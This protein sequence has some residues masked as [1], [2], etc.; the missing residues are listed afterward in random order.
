MMVGHACAPED[1]SIG[2]PFTGANG[3]L[4]RDLLAHAGIASL[5]ECY[6][7]NCCKCA[8]YT[9]RD[10]KKE[11]KKKHWKA[12]QPHFIKE[13]EHVQPKVLVALGAQAFAWLT[14][15]S[16]VAKFYR[17]SLPC[18][19]NEDIP[20]FP[21]RQPAQLF[22]C[23]D[24]VEAQ[25]LR[26]AMIQDLQ[27]LKN[28]VTSIV[29]KS[30]AQ[31]SDLDYKTITN[32][33]E[34][35][36]LFAELERHPVLGFDLET[37]DLFPG[38]DER[39]L[40]AGFSW[41]PKVG[42][43]LPLHAR[44][45][46]ATHYWPDGYVEQE[47]VPRLRKILSEKE[48][49]GHNAIQFDQ[50]WTRAK[51]GVHKLRILFD[52][53]LAHFAI[54]EER[55]TH[56]LEQIAV[57]YGGMKTWKRDFNPHDTEQLCAY[58]CKDVD[59]VSRLRP[60]FESM[61]SQGERWLLDNVLVPLAH[62]LFEVEYA[63]VR[64]SETALTDLENQLTA[65]IDASEDKI[66]QHKAVL[67]FM[68]D[69]N[70]P[71]DSESP[72][73]VRDVMQKYL[74]LKKVK[75]T[76]SGLYSTDKEALS[77]HKNDPFVAD[78]QENRRLRKLRSTYCSQLREELRNGVVHTSY[79]VH[80]TVTGRPSSSDP[81]LMNIPRE[82][83]AA[84]VLDDGS[85]IKKL[86]LPDPG[87][88]LLQADFCLT[89]DTEVIT[90]HGV[91]ELRDVVAKKPAVLSSADGRSVQFSKVTAGWSNGKKPVF[92]VIT[93]DGSFVRCT[94]EHRWMLKNGTFKETRNLQPGDRLAHVKSGTRGPKGAYKTWYVGSYFNYF[95]QHQV[96]AE[97][98]FGPPPEGF[99]VDHIDGNTERNV[100]GNIRYLPISQ[101]RSQG[102]GR[103]W[104]SASSAEREAKLQSL[105]EGN[106][107]R[108]YS[109]ALNPNFG[110][111]RG[112]ERSCPVCGAGF[113]SYPS[114][115]KIFCSKK[116]AANRHKAVVNHK[117]LVV[118]PCAEEEEVFD[119]TVDGTHTFVL[120]NGM[121]SHNCQAELRVLA[122][123]SGDQQLLGI[124]QRGEDAHAATAAIVY[125]IPLS[126][127]TKAQRN[128]AKP[129]NFGIPYGMSEEGLIQ[130]FMEAGGS[131]Q[132]AKNFLT[133]HQKKFHDVW[134]YME[135]QA[136]IVRKFRKQTTYFGRSRRY[137]QVD[138]RALRQAYN[139]P[140]QSLA[141]E[142]T[143]LCLI[144]IAKTIR[145]LQLNAR[146][147][148]TVYD[149]IAWSVSPEHFWTLAKVAHHIMS[150]IHFPWMKVP[151][152]ADLEAGW[153]WGDLKKV[154][155]N[156]G[157][158]G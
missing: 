101:N 81:N 18:V 83:T 54:D 15:F 144:R 130:K 70:K 49:F 120:A 98:L 152:A 141:S 92:L 6:F 100:T 154:D 143:L 55:G 153:N 11:L 45:T 122:S 64:L 14:G 134:K 121:I 7:T 12:C 157:K 26:S 61:L 51:L 52:T 148:L 112:E 10:Q 132:E 58:L 24:P 44:G 117:V 149:S 77:F 111:R 48:V 105:Q 156:L 158:V 37:S 94:A 108:G 95:P 35:L 25:S 29:A 72:H 63:G 21:L 107:R 57:V 16:G 13:L 30:T 102:A 65:K 28:H 53:Q 86:F 41:G 33:Q 138:N 114:H 87:Q 155:L 110:N 137:V 133:T 113:Y 82:D 129:I 42:R 140:I 2:K 1:D 97:Y 119:I 88:I 85:L 150:T 62:E 17:K 135:D 39:I 93:D 79:K 74:G 147:L 50:K 151:M 90:E 3:R 56:D 8:L 99:E 84:K 146:T 103:W 127:V 9:K 89:G 118:M 46:L 136:A 47:L 60:I 23:K 36:E 38:P 4:F 104:G 80:G 71:F 67:A 76:G 22:H 75:E 128:Q 126:Q 34:V 78:L 68:L 32:H 142:L 106:R 131:E 125:E 145:E 69:S 31:N 116:C 91:M 96:L 43:A 5:R 27:W 124:Y 139:F 20:V 66:R 115:N 123:I 73:H 59:A 40:A 19:L 109:G